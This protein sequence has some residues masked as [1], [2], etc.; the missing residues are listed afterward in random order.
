[1]TITE[2][3]Q[4]MQGRRSEMAI[5]QASHDKMVADFQS[6]ISKNQTRFAQ[7][8]GA[9][10]ELTELMQTYEQRNND[11]SGSGGNP[12]YAGGLFNDRAGAG[13]RV[14]NPVVHRKLDKPSAAA[15]KTGAGHNSPDRAGNL[16]AEKS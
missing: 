11:G 15:R 2:L 6:Q 12:E 5:L 4:R 10:A 8:T 16:G 1:M 14:G 9:I 7:L 3:E 13:N